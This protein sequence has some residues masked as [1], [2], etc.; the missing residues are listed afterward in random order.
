MRIKHRDIKK[1]CVIQLQPFG[2]VFLSTSYFEALKEFYPKAT[3]TYLMKEPF[4][5]I[6]K[7]HP[8]I[9]KIIAIKKESGLRYLIERVKTFRKIRKEKFDLVIDQQ[10][11]P[12]SQVLSFISGAPYRIGYKSERK[13]LEFLY[14]IHARFGPVR[15]S[16][17]Q[18]FDIVKPLGM[19]EKSYKMRY[20]IPRQAFDHV[21]TWFKEQGIA[22][23]K[24]ILFSPGSKLAYKKWSP[25]GFAT[26]ATRLQDQGYQIILMCAPGEENDVKDVADRMAQAPFIAPPTALHNAAALI[27]RIPLFLCNDGGINHLSVAVGN[28]VIAIFGLSNPQAWSPATEYPSHRHLYHPGFSKDDPFFGIT[29]DQV[30]DAILDFL[31]TP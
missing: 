23:E 28:K 26:V 21:D 2:D 14:N 12:S 22:P 16:A 10:N 30:F 7:D 13:N 4:Q 15:Y 11:M 8:A 24:S 5:I 18:K 19:P 9:D 31:K 27:N 29:T 25:D 17:S 3:L 6:V 20:T 1:I